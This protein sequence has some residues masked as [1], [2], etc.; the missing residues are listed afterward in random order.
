MYNLGMDDLTQQ[1]A[2]NTKD[3]NNTQRRAFNIRINGEEHSARSHGGIANILF[4]ID[5]QLM[6]VSECA[7][8]L[9]INDAISTASGGK[10][11][12]DEIGI[13][14][15]P[16][17]ASWE[18]RWPLGSEIDVD[19]AFGCQCVDYA[20]AFWYAQTGRPVSTGG[21][22]AAYGIWTAARAENQGTE[23]TLVTSWSDLK[24]GDWVVWQSPEYGHVGMVSRIEGSNVYFWSQNYRNASDL[25]SPL[26][27]D[28]IPQTSNFF[29]FLGGFRYEG[30]A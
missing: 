4:P 19:G 24:P 2:S 20:N 25:G 23:F 1:I 3:L 6:Q 30:W 5:G 7:F 13:D 8:K 22:G 27:E 21:T 29:S 18:A 11:T 16:T 9:I 26:S 10:W 17:L 12:P 15:Y 14:K 28:I